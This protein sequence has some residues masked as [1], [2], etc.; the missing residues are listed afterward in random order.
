MK[1]LDEMTEKE[2]S[3]LSRFVTGVELGV[4]LSGKTAP[5]LLTIATEYWGTLPIDNPVAALL[6]ELIERLE[7][8]YNINQEPDDE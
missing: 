6:L 7:H 8:V 2:L 1:T 4:R 5:E 3:N